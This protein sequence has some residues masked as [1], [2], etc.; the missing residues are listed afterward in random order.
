MANRG[1]RNFL[2]FRARPKETRYLTGRTKNA[3][4]SQTLDVFERA[5]CCPFRVFKGRSRESAHSRLMLSSIASCTIKFKIKLRTN[6]PRGWYTIKS[7]ARRKPDARELQKVAKNSVALGP[8]EDSVQTW[9]AAL[10]HSPKQKSNT[11]LYERSA[12]DTSKHP[13]LRH[14]TH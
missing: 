2:T 14:A 5:S 11:L 13:N 9:C 6:S 10:L 1:A 8:S 12:K 3:K 4:P 7:T